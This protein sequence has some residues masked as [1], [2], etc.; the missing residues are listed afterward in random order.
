MTLFGTKELK[1]STEQ[2]TWRAKTS[3]WIVDHWSGDDSILIIDTIETS[4]IQQFEGQCSSLINDCVKV[5]YQQEFTFRY[6]NTTTNSSIINATTIVTRPFATLENRLNYVRRLN[7]ATSL[8]QVSECSPITVY[9][10]DPL[11]EVPSVVPSFSPSKTLMINDTKSPPSTDQDLVL[12]IIAVVLLG[13]LFVCALLGGL[14]YF[15]LTARKEDDDIG[16]KLLTRM[17]IIKTP[18]PTEGFRPLADDAEQ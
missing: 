16:T 9:T 3:D 8:V 1:K 2:D 13:T 12:W 18:D 7:N 17:K 6:L 11:T 10:R 4:I 5:Y 14:F 15:R